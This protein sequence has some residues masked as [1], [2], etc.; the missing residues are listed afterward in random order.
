MD[1]L[2]EL[3]PIG[4][5]D[6]IPLARSVMTVGRRKSNDICLDFAN[7]SGNHCEFIFKEGF[8]RIRDLGSGNGIKINN[9]KILSTEPRAL[10]PGD[11]VAI[12]NH[13]YTIEYHIEESSRDALHKMLDQGEDIM[14]QSL[15]EKAGLTKMKN[16]MDDDDD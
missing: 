16:D 6:S 7:V 8:W 9:E 2:G 1:I 4:G 10:R 11:S 14:S 3:V 5:G 12:A 15:L 13:K